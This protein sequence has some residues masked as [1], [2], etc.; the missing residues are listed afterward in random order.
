MGNGAIIAGARVCG[1]EFTGPRKADAG[2]VETLQGCK[3]VATGQVGGGVGWPQSDG[4]VSVMQRRIMLP[5]IGQNAGQ[6]Q[7]RARSPGGGGN[8]A[9]AQPRSANTIPHLRRKLGAE[10]QGF[11]MPRGRA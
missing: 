5:K 1:A 10:P 2:P 8:C 9:P 6:H 3:R 7:V 4:L 11:G